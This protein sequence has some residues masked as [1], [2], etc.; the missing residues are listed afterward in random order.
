MLLPVSGLATGHLGR[1]VNLR[2]ENE[3][4]VPSE[5]NMIRVGFGSDSW[6]QNCTHT[7]T[8]RVE[9]PQVTQNLNLNY[10]PYSLTISINRK[11]TELNKMT[12]RTDAA[13]TS[14]KTKQSSGA[15]PQNQ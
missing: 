15:C 4:R 1:R 6:V 2:V 9:N 5:P 14:E 13:A 8:C 12:T 10:H 7:C 3:T 11:V